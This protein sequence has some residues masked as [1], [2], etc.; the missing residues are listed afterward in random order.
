V[1]VRIAV[2]GSI[3]IVVPRSRWLMTIVPQVASATMIGA[4]IAD[5]KPAFLVILAIVPGSRR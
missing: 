4:P 1:T 2:G 3:E 5:R